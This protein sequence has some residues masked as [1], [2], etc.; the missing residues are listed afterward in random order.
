VNHEVN[1]VIHLEN[2]LLLYHVL[3]DVMQ[4]QEQV[5]YVDQYF[6]ENMFSLDSKIKQWKYKFK[7]K[8]GEIYT[9]R[10]RNFYRN[11]E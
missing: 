6:E 9:V 1:R 3:D 11:L 4:I 10:C 8:L 5:L 2:L 7:L